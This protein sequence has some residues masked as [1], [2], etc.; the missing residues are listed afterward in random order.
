MN[1]IDLLLIIACSIFGFLFK[2]SFWFA[3]IVVYSIISISSLYFISKHKK[4]SNQACENLKQIYQVF[5]TELNK[6][7][8]QKNQGKLTVEI[9]IDQVI[10]IYNNY[11]EKIKFQYET[12]CQ[13][14]NNKKQNIFTKRI[15]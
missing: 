9:S 11:L 2:D 10:E 3:F 4:I 1:L 5:E 13:N 15:I 7:K 8:D 12:E 14:F 6:V